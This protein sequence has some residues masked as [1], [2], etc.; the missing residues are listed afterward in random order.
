M[1]RVISTIIFAFFLCSSAQAENPMPD[2][3]VKLA[4]AHIASLKEKPD[5]MMEARKTFC[6]MFLYG[7]TDFAQLQYAD[8]AQLHAQDNSLPPELAG[9]DAAIRYR[10]THPESAHR[11]L[12]AFG[13]KKVIRTGMWR[14][15]FEMSQFVSSDA[16]KPGWWLRIY[17]DC[18]EGKLRWK[19]FSKLKA[20]YEIPDELR[21]SI[22]DKRGAEAS[23]RIVGYLSPIGEYGHLGSYTRELLA[24]QIEALD[25]DVPNGVPAQQPGKIRPL[26]NGYRSYDGQPTPTKNT[27]EPSVERE[28]R[29]PVDSA[30]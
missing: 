28:L 30:Q 4:D 27:N 22:D 9:V 14:C 19:R 8:F 17:T 20:R 25:A 24:I 16:K 7:Y 15:G 13:Y 10:E 23:V 11:V 2:F 3:V 29:R 6:A 21:K 12:T 5:D 1:I 26:N 18:K